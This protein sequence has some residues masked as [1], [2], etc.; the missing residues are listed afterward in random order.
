MPLTPSTQ[1]SALLR[2]VVEREHVGVGCPVAAAYEAAE[3]LQA[4]GRDMD[5]LAAFFGSADGAV[6]YVAD[7]IHGVSRRTLLFA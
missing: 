3:E 5:G 7:E 6:G 4:P 1:K 2:Y